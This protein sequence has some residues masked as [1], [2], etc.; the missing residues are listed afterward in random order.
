M[1]GARALSTFTRRADATCDFAADNIMAPLKR[2]RPA[3]VNGESDEEDMRSHNSVNSSPL[4]PV[5]ALPN[6]SVEQ[7]ST[8]ARAC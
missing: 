2:A 5:A 1:T 3:A 7:A 4:V 8:T 6:I